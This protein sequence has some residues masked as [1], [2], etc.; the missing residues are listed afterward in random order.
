ML[1]RVMTAILVGLF[2]STLYAPFAFVG[3]PQSHDVQMDAA[4][5]KPQLSQIAAEVSLRLAPS[6]VAI[7]RFHR[8]VPNRSIPESSLARIHVLRI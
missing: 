8:P 1:R 7:D 6:G 2:L 3:T 5:Q 4:G